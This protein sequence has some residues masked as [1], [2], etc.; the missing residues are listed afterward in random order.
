M[1]SVDVFLYFFE[2]KNPG[3]KLWMSFNGIAGRVLLTLFQ[4]SYKGFKGKFFKICC[5][6]H[7]PTLL[8]G[9][10]LYWVEK[11]GLK[12]PRSLEDLSLP[13]QEVCQLL[14]RLGVV[15]NTAKLIKLECSPKNLKG[16]IGILSCFYFYLLEHCVGSLSYALLFSR[17]DMVLNAEKRRMLAEV[18]FKRKAGVGLSV[19]APPALISAPSP[20]AP[21]PVDLRQKG[22]IEATAFEDEDTCSGLVFKRKRVVDLAVP[23]QSA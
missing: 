4:Q 10:P 12:K 6:T 21:A 18:A 13:D 15:F 8:D 20:S 23:A 1:P 11:T 16:Y 14:S 2:A 7:D 5:N 17:A 22:V 3:K 9:F 19:D